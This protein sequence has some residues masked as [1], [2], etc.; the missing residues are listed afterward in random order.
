MAPFQVDVLKIAPG[1][2]DVIQ[3]DRDPATGSFRFQDALNPTPL[4][5][6]DLASLSTVAGV[7][8]VGRAGSGAKYTTLTSA[9]AAVPTTSSATNPSVILVFPG[10]YNEGVTVTRD[11]VTI[12]GFG[13]VVIAPTLSTHALTIQT[14]VPSTPRQFTARNIVFQAAADN[15]SAVA[16]VGGTGS[17]VGLQGIRFEGCTFVSTGDAGYTVDGQTCGALEFVGCSSTGSL[18]T[19][20]LHLTQVASASVRDSVFP[21]LEVSYASAS[22]LPAGATGNFS[23][24]GSQFGSALVNLTSGGTFTADGCTFG[25]TTFQGNRTTTIYNSRLSSLVVDGTTVATLVKTDPGTVTGSGVLSWDAISGVESFSSASSHTVAF[26]VPTV[27]SDYSVFLDTGVPQVAYISD[28]DETGFTITF[29]GPVTTNV[30][31]RV[32]RN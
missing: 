21:S 8:V 14:S 29:S 26:D 30:R 22:P 24:F 16:V 5:L 17:N 19:A 7:Y 4:L 3:L 11:G 25:G 20:S 27:D 6:R 10:I 28:R 9:L 12:V 15:H 2:G 18:S 23:L 31:W 13:R 1:S 32:E